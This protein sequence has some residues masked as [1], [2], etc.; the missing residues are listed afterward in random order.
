MNINII[1]FSLFGFAGDKEV[2]RIFVK[3]ENFLQYNL[4]NVMSII[5][6]PA[7]VKHKSQHK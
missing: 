7:V 3:D 6:L 2:D 1:R 5:K 4:V